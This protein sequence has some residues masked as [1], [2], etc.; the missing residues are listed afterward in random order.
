MSEIVLHVHL[1]PVQPFIAEARRTRDIW[2]GSFLLSWL[3][4]EAL[5]AALGPAE[6]ALERVLTPRSAATD[7]TVHAVRTKATKP[8]LG[9]FPNHFSVRLPPDPELSP[10]E[11]V[12][13]AI[14][15]VEA[16]VRGKWIALATE[17][18]KLI[19]DTV[20]DFDAAIEE[21]TLGNI[22]LPAREI[23]RAQIGTLDATPMWE[24]YA[25]G[26]E[27]GPWRK[28]AGDAS[29]LDLRKLQRWSDDI[30]GTPAVQT[31]ALC[32]MIPGWC[33][34]S[35]VEDFTSEKGGKLQDAFW[36]AV[37]GVVVA[38]RYGGAA[39]CKR[40]VEC[41]DITPKERLSAPALVKRL[42]PLLDDNTLKRTIGWTPIIRAS[43]FPALDTEPEPRRRSFLA[44]LLS[45]LRFLPPPPASASGEE[46]RGDPQE[47]DDVAGRQ[48]RSL[49][50]STSYM[51]AARWIARAHRCAPDKAQAVAAAIAA[52]GRHLEVAEATLFVACTCEGAPIPLAAVDGACLFPTSVDR[53]AKDLGAAERAPYDA[54]IKALSELAAAPIDPAH[55]HGPHIGR[56][57]PVYA[58][59]RADGDE[60][61]RRLGA[62]PEL[63][64]ALGIFTERLRAGTPGDDDIGAIARNNG[65]TLYASADEMIAICPMEDALA[66]ARDVRSSFRRAVAG[67]DDDATISVAITYAH[68]QVPLTWV[69]QSGQKL[70]NN[71]AKDVVG[72]DCLAIEAIEA[73]GRKVEW[74]A[75]WEPL[76]APR[77]IASKVMPPRPKEL[78]NRKLEHPSVTSG[79]ALC[80]LSILLDAAFTDAP[81]IGGNP[82][83]HS[84]AARLGPLMFD[85][86]NL[87]CAHRVDQMRP[88]S[89]F[90]PSEPNTPPWEIALPLCQGLVAD[91]CRGLSRP[92][93]EQ[94][95]AALVAVSATEFI[96]FQD[97][98]ATRRYE[99]LRLS[100]SGIKLLRLLVEN[101]RRFSAAAPSEA[102]A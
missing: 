64:R 39:A 68:R 26:V 86:D 79:G 49:W 37:R 19:F 38:W 81:A 9:T 35:G 47:R 15:R 8:F 16:R 83:L 60:M 71:L 67:I 30:A 87:S 2:A 70:L 80:S 50:P 14:A 66:L 18:E 72:G 28:A 84:F 57:A 89:K 25:I 53:M 78:A 29:P 1:G 32:S 27:K 7:I 85:D 12:A 58:I 65:V 61:G 88:N 31:G 95:A 74:V 23:F 44:E 76:I 77:P 36:E 5:D 82:F 101:D 34:I 99:L 11:V 93:I 41:L 10:E 48:E 51:A 54:V 46:A 55:P 69:M 20:I 24:I 62:K 73:G 75:H 43:T 56:P 102:A 21:Q 91:T 40:A 94:L 59:V 22:H 52:C 96:E 6:D 17:V 3:S 45:R 33:E 42:F 100:P 13:A 63:S 97:E 90:R 92:R 98:I 4:A